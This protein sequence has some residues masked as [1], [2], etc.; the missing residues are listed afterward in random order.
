MIKEVKLT[1]NEVQAL[2]NLNNKKFN[3]YQKIT[4]MTHETNQEDLQWWRN[5][6][7]NHD[8]DPKGRYEISANKD[9][10]FLNRVK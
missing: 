5:I 10:V 8:L 4:S 9:G 6:Y 2:Q 1:E 7:K 3:S